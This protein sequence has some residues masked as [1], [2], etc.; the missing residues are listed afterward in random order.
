MS[1]ELESVL[2]SS[3][4]T[5]SGGPSSLSRVSRSLPTSSAIASSSLYTG[6]T[7]EYVSASMSS[8]VARICLATSQASGYRTPSGT[9]GAHHQRDSGPGLDRQIAL[10]DDHSGQ[11]PVGQGGDLLQVT[12]RGGLSPHGHRPAQQAVPAP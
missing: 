1:W 12:A 8:P 11:Q 3:T 2:P 5:A 6:T 10:R 9:A 4:S 7:I